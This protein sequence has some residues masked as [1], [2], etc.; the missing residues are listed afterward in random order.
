MCLLDADFVFFSWI[1]FF[2]QLRFARR[3]EVPEVLTYDPGLR[4]RLCARPAQQQTVPDDVVAAE[5]DQ[6]PY[7]T[8]QMDWYFQRHGYHPLS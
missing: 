6:L 1:D 8:A 3:D 2:A 7:L 5:W 4:K